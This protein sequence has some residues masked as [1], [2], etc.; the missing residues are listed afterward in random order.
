MIGDIERVSLCFELA[1]KLGRD[2]GAKRG[3]DHLRTV[4]QMRIMR[5]R[6]AGSSCGVEAD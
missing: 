6:I 1:K 3:Q 5:L 4:L 2:H